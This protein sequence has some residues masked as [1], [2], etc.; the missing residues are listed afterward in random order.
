MTIIFMSDQLS[1]LEKKVLIE[2][3]NNCR[4]SDRMLAKKLSVSQPT[5]TR[6]RGKLSENNIISNFTINPNLFELGLNLKV[7]TYVRFSSEIE[8]KLLKKYLDDSDHIYFAAEG[9]GIRGHTL[10]LDSVHTDFAHYSEYI[11]DF[12]KKFSG[13]IVELDSFFINSKSLLKSHSWGTLLKAHLDQMQE[14][15]KQESN[16]KNELKK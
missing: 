16:G 12:R 8:P 11:R 3:S 15:T 1:A 10:M 2:L 13:K 4:I 7:F 6:I 5:I 9:E 14:K